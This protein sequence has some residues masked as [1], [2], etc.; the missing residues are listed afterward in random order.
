MENN[1]E[2]EVV[3]YGDPKC[4]KTCPQ[5]VEH[6]TTCV[7]M[8]LATELLASA[9]DLDNTEVASKCHR[10]QKECADIL[11]CEPGRVDRI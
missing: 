11:G 6:N 1:N 7:L 2:K 10:F 4:K 5:R 3:G 9:L 8:C